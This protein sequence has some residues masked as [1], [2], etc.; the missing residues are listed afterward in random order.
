MIELLPEDIRNKVFP[1]TSY[2]PLPTPLDAALAKDKIE[3]FMPI[4]DV[5]GYPIPEQLFNPHG[6]V[7]DFVE[8]ASVSLVGDR[9]RGL[10]ALALSK[11]PSAPENFARVA[12]WVRYTNGVYEPVDYPLEDTFYFD[13]ET[14]VRLGNFPVMAA[15]VSTEAWYL[16][17]H[18]S[19]VTEAPWEQIL[20]P[21][22]KYKTIVAHSVSF[23]IA[24]LE[25]TYENLSLQERPMGVCTMSLGM[26]QNG[27]GGS[28]QRALWLKSRKDDKANKSTHRPAWVDHV[29]TDSLVANY[30]F[31]VRKPWGDEVPKELRDIFVNA[32]GVNAVRLQL[33]VLV[34]YV[35]QDVSKGAELFSVQWNR[36]HNIFTNSSTPIASMLLESTSLLRVHDSWHIQIQRAEA[37]YLSKSG[38]LKDKLA[39]LA[40][41][42][43]DK[44]LNGFDV[45]SDPWLN[46]LDWSPLGNTAKR[47]GY[48][49][50]WSTK[51]VD[52]GLSLAS[53]LVPL[54]M[55][56]TWSGGA[57]FYHKMQKWMWTDETGDRHKVPHP[58]GDDE[59]CG[60]LFGKSYLKYV[61]EGILNSADAESQDILELLQLAKSLSYWRSFRD[62]FR[63]PKKI[64]HFQNGNFIVPGTFIW[65][66]LSLR[67]KESLWLTMSQAKETRIGSEFMH[68]VRPL[69][70]NQVIMGAD[71]DTEEVRI[72]SA[73]GDHINSKVIGGTAMS[74]SALKGSKELGTDPH[75]VMAN[76]AQVSRDDGKV[77]NFR[78]QF[79]GGAYTVTMGLR[80]AHLDWSM[81]YCRSLADKMIKAKKGQKKFG[82]W[83]GGTDSSAHNYMS[84]W[85]NRDAPRRP[86]FG[87]MVP[88]SILGIYDT[89]RK[90]FT[91]RYN[92]VVQGTGSDIRA[93]L[94]VLA[95]Y[96]A[97]ILN[98][99]PRLMLWRHDEVWFSIDKSH[100]EELGVAM[101]QAHLW[102]WALLYESLGMYNLPTA[103]AGFSEIHVDLT[104]RKYVGAPTTSASGGQEIPQGIVLTPSSEDKGLYELLRSNSE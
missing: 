59:N 20:I 39:A 12:G 27:M 89:D 19:V 50:W 36:W 22:G 62:R 14:L 93:A 43:V 26:A 44:W 76:I 31:F 51:K 75:T 47:P 21:I 17:L 68:L 73:L 95:H 41:S 102:A 98:I 16:W 87:T 23:D 4:T 82:K 88:E 48:P 30:E 99:N 97:H 38:E 42:W 100:T 49:R 78:I 74:Q 3:R 70:D 64:R 57:V 15:A 66:T 84:E 28:K 24:R 6:S 52:K 9:L 25:E 56:L 18:P 10:K 61:E 1:N 2:E 11:L 86:M 58:K 67:Q 91:S 29:T 46:Q 90:F 104:I 32:P 96:F 13:T 35:F 85:A 69:W 80:A 92:N 33:D 55:R 8:E 7:A 60:N 77:G 71:V 54:L 53:S 37:S 79:G 101:N 45:K 83:F 63:S 103:L 72:A 40:Q 81:E 65:G 5:K 34:P 94:T